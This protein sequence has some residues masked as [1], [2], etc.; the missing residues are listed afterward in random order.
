MMSTTNEIRTALD[1]VDSH[2]RDLWLKMGAALKDEL[3]EEGFP[4]WDQWS[5]SAQNY[6]ARAAQATWKSLKSGHVRINTLFYTAMQNGYQPTKPTV[7]PSAEEIAK[8]QAEAEQKRLQAIEAQKQAQEV[9]KQK[10]QYIWQKA[11][12]AQLAHPYLQAKSITDPECIKGIKQNLYKDNQNLII[13]MYQNKEIVSLQFINQDGSKR[14]MGDGQKEG[15]YSLIGDAKKMVDGFYMAEGFATAASIYEATGQPV[16]V[17]FDAG[18]LVRVAENLKPH[19]PNTEIILAADND[20][21]NKGLTKATEAAQILGDNARVICP[22][23]T[24]EQ[25][26]HYQQQ[27]GE[28]KSPSDFNDLHALEGL[29]QLKNVLN[30]DSIPIMD[31]PTKNIA[32]QNEPQAA[33]QAAFLIPS[34][35]EQKTQ[36]TAKRASTKKVI[37]S[38]EPDLAR[39]QEKTPKGK[40]QKTVDPAPTILPQ[41]TTPPAS[42]KEVDNLPENTD[43]PKAKQPEPASDPIPSIDPNS[44]EAE[45]PPL[46]QDE[47]KKIIT[48][49][50]YKM[51]P[52]GLERR[53]LVADGQYLSADNATT[54]LFEDK[55][56]K[57]STARNDTQIAQDMLEVAKTKGWDA[58][59][60][61]GTKEFKQ[62]MYVLAESQG[63]KT[64]GYKATEADRVLVERLREDQSLNSIEEKASLYTQ[65]SMENNPA[66]EKKS[67][68]PDVEALSKADRIMATSSIPTTGQIET[69]PK[70]D[71]DVDVPLAEIGQGKIPS[72]VIV[73]AKNIKTHALDTDVVTTSKATYDKKAAKLSKPEKAKLQFFERNTLDVIR[74]LKGDA[75]QN[76]LKNYYDHMADKMNG[77][78]LD[79]PTPLQVPSPRGEHTRAS[80]KTQDRNQDQEVER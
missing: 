22:Q 74:D 49:L 9:T 79:V 19:Y 11:V 57:L 26:Q 43:S 69:S 56:K 63:I 5:S 38:I 34:E 1:Y 37:N 12:S 71:R 25:I 54:V 59:K 10:A 35:P 28:G 47:F 80:D 73:Q 44:T 51:P 41:T 36:E 53:Y 45:K 15:S 67:G 62:M 24:E 14:Y 17:A 66:S 31:N 60:L 4:I 3:G 7:A 72:E 46:S 32:P 16:L 20:P 42:E 52:A 40:V 8:R 21:D 78:T 65:K 29:D 6:N 30:K 39:L 75:R 76:A 33:E 64:S 77:K 61:S 27:Y 23:F 2:D 58:I 68:Q 55:G 50:N 18:N 48:D 13:P 70:A